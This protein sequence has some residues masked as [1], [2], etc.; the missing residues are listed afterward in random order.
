MINELR[1][2]RSYEKSQVVSYSR[3]CTRQKDNERVK[4]SDQLERSDRYK[5]LASHV[6]TI[7]CKR[8]VYRPVDREEK[9][10]PIDNDMGSPRVCTRRI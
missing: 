1:A 6:N 8:Q 2:H 7:H 10:L 4:H 3:E 9:N 5:T